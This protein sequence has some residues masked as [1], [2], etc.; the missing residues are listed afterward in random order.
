MT[1]LARLAYP[2][3]IACGALFLASELSSYVAGI[4]LPVDGGLTAI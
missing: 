1:P 2:D 3:E 4:D